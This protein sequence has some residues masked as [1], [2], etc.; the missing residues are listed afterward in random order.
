MSDG[1]LGGVGHNLAVERFLFYCSAY[2]DF[3]MVSKAYPTDSS[4]SS[5]SSG[6]SMATAYL[7]LP[8]LGKQTISN[9]KFCLSYMSP[10]LRRL[11]W[12]KERGKP[13]Q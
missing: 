7:S 11:F 12:R 6:T 8:A 4:M 9:Y 3:Y 13:G 10:R 2:T 1:G 5:S